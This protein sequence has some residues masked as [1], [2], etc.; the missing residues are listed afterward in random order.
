MLYAVQCETIF[1]K[2]GMPYGQKSIRA[3]FRI[4][5]APLT[6]TGADPAPT[7]STKS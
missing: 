7:G 1:S 2:S 5:T 4:K 3:N 6:A